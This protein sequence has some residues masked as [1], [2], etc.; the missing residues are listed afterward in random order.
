MDLTEEPMDP[1]VTSHLKCDKC[2]PSGS[3]VCIPRVAF[4]IENDIE[5]E[6]AVAQLY[7]AFV[8]KWEQEQLEE[9]RASKF[10]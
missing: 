8:S 6:E 1:R 5:F 3:H 9:P 7:D 4:Y 2:G 10:F